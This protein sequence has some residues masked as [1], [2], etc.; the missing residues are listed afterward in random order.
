MINTTGKL[1]IQTAQQVYSQLRRKKPASRNDLK[2]YVKVFLGPNVTDRRIC[3][4]HNSPMD[5]LWHSFGADFESKRK[6]NAD[7][8]IWANRGGGKT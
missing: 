3:P 6:P 4:E 5:Y 7:A 2:N 1:D 8:V